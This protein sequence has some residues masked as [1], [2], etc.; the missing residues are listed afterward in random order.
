[1]VRRH[2]PVSGFG[3]SGRPEREVDFVENA[4]EIRHFAIERDSERQ[5]RGEAWDLQTAL[6]VADVALGQPGRPC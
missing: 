2:L 1:M 3:H 6:H 4:D 5:N